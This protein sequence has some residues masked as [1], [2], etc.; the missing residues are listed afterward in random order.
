[1]KTHTGSQF[2]RD[3]IPQVSCDRGLKMLSNWLES[4]DSSQQM[5]TRHTGCRFARHLENILQVSVNGGCRCCRID[6]IRLESNDSSQQ[7]T[8]CHTGCRLARHLEKY[9]ASICEGRLKMLS[10]RTTRHN[11]WRPVIPEVSVH[12]SQFR[13][14]LVNFNFLLTTPFDACKPVRFT[15][16]NRQKIFR[17]YLWRGVEDV[18]ESNDSSR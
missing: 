7:M 5:T 1:M 13:I 18:V 6:T 15:L 14:R 9:Y 2:A 11:K 17:K 4:N 12:L 16:I 3:F 8:T 10:N